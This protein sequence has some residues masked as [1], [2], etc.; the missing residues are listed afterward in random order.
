MRAERKAT[1]HMQKPHQ[2][3]HTKMEASIETDVGIHNSMSEGKST[4]QSVDA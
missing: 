3:N 4:L 2:Q 1:T